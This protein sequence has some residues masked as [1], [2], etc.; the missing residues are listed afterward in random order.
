[1]LPIYDSVFKL[2]TVSDLA[3]FVDQFVKK[4]D[5][6]NPIVIGNSLGGHVALVYAIDYSSNYKALVL[7]G[8]SGLFEN[9][10]GGT[11]PKRGDYDYI[12][13][14]TAYTFYSPE[15]ATKELV[16]EVFDIVNDRIKVLKIINMSKSAMRHNLKEDLAKI[17][18]PA[19]LVWGKNDNITPPHVAEEFKKGLVNSE[20]YWIDKCGHAPMMEQPIE[21]NEILDR[22]LLKI[23][24]T[25]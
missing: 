3:G 19:L 10:M 15:T 21:F 24:K 8:S 25:Y 2:P 1:M 14:R 5:Y 16:D 4:M 6:K 22:F 17:T 20:L 13:E 11:F 7:T 23:Y 18:K 9:S 12:K